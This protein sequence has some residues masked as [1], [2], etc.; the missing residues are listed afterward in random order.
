M[1]AFNN[2]PHK[3]LDSV[4]KQPTQSATA[5]KA[6]TQRVMTN[7]SNEKIVMPIDDT[8][9]IEDNFYFRRKKK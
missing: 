1:Q 5:Q 3:K 9:E 2:L 8:N 7:V 6:K 4:R